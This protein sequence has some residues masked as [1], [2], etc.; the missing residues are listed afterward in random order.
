MTA[1]VRGSKLDKMRN[2]NIKWRMANQ[3]SIAGYA[4]SKRL[5][6]HGY[7]QRMT[8]DRLSKVILDWIPEGR[9]R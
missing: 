7:V 3:N 6:W 2:I 9:R 5:F 4:P 1:T 8:G